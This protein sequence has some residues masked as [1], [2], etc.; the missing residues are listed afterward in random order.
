MQTQMGDEKLSI[1][2]RMISENDLR[3]LAR[4]GGH[5]LPSSDLESDSQDVVK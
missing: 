3:S 4:D 1:L 2:G 5:I